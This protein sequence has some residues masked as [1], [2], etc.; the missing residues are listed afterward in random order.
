MGDRCRRRKFASM[1]MREKAAG[2]NAWVEYGK[3]REEIA[4]KARNL[5][6]QCVGRPALGKLGYSVLSTYIGPWHLCNKDGSIR[7]C[8]GMTMPEAIQEVLKE[9]RWATLWGEFLEW[10]ER[11]KNDMSALDMAACMEICPASLEC[12][13]VV[14]LHFHVY[15]RSGVHMRHPPCATRLYFQGAKPHLATV[16]GGMPTVKSRNSW[17]G[18]FYCVVDRYGSVFRHGSRRPFKDFQVSAQWIVSLLQAKKLTPQ[19][20]KPLTLQT[21]HNVGRNLKELEVIEQEE[22]QSQF[23]RHWSKRNRRGGAWPLTNCSRCSC[24]WP[25]CAPSAWPNPRA[26]RFAPAKNCCHSFSASCPLR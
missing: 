20:A 21:C 26:R 8:E 15:L 14:R 3:P 23:L 17:V 9:P 11:L 24:A 6:M 22:M 16:L 2:A 25:V 5:F 19:Q 1:S 10:C 12:N 4:E 18:Y 13:R 7:M